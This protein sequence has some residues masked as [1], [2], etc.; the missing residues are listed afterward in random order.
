MPSRILEKEVEDVE[1]N[2]REMLNSYNIDPENTE[3]LRVLRN[4]IGEYF[5]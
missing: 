3:F 1:Q 4:K 5:T 2:I